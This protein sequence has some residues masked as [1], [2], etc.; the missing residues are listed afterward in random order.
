MPRLAEKITLITGAARGIGAAIASA[1]IAEGAWVV[2]TDMADDLGAATA[3]GLGERAVYQHLDVREEADWPAAM[4]W[5]LARWGRLDVLVNN[6]GI[7][8]FEPG[9]DGTVGPQD[10]EQVSLAD[11]HAVHRT[12]LDGVFLG[13]RA[14]LRAMRPAGQGSIINLS[15]RSGQV[16]IA[17]AAAYAASKAAVRNHSKT[18][19]LWCAEQ[20]LAIR[21]NSIHPGAILTPMWEPLLGS[22]PEREER[23]RAVV[24]DTPLRRFGTPAEVA[25]VAVL[26]ASDEAAYM[27]GSELTIDGGLL[28]G[29]A[30]APRAT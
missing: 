6:A 2:L 20:G 14:A 11:W 19:A 7:T 3:A 25:A 27:T 9:T 12:N 29:S 8:G 16:G 21:C 30:A 1:F 22:G 4:A 18:V 23:L 26:L 24:C 5:L 28:A 15:S 13:C 10:P 17:G